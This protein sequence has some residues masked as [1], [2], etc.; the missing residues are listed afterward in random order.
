M[1]EKEISEKPTKKRRKL[2]VFLNILIIFV[3]VVALGVAGVLI[4][5]KRYLTP[6]WVNGQ[7]MYPT[8]N[9]N[10][11]K[12]DGTLYGEEGSSTQ[13]GSKMIDYGVM[14]KHDR[15]LNNLKRFDVV[16]CKYSETDS[17]DKIKRVVGLPGETIK[18]GQEAE[19]GTLYIKGENDFYT[20]D[21]PI[22]NKYV[23]S[24]V[25]PTGEITLGNDEYYVLGDNRA[26]SSDSRTNGPIARKLLVGKVV[27]LCAHCEVRLKEDGTLEPFNIKH[28]FPR[29][30]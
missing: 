22:D 10:A 18:F 25:Y 16:V 8:L 9:T 12:P 30:L 5:Q 27:A 1:D 7:S 20:V 4:Y 28:F 3:S 17:S 26:H 11:I 21:Q 24:G 23:T 15:A 14:D 6:F 2:S 29:F 19:N 13:P